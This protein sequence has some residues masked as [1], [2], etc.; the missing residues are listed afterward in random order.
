MLLK[1]E[2]L[3]V[4][5][6]GREILHDINF[7]L[8]KGEVHALL[9][10]NGSGKTSL[11]MTIMGFEKFKVTKGRIIFKGE[12]ITH[13][14][15]YERAKMGI[16]LGFQ[17]PPVVRGVKTRQLI[18]MAAQTQ[19]RKVNVE[20]LAEKLHLEEFLE[21]DI[22]LGFSG[23]EMKRSELVQLLAQ[24]PQLVM[25][26]E[27]ESGVD[28]K[29][30][31]LL[32]KVI[33]ELLERELEPKQKES[34]KEMKSK[35][36]KSALIITHTGHILNFVPAD[37]GHVLIEGHLVCSGNPKEILKTVEKYGYEECAKC[38]R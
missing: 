38:L 19:N 22:N 27:P 25:L 35:R 37:K 24:D 8:P 13:L 5:V 29:N 21:R 28:L 10:P 18:E 2:N 20:A 26:D 32:G 4:E 17:R 36:K 1:I 23:G 12:D 15:V 7:T 3:R 31:A 9:G 16:G 11:V 33:N 34:I 14:P 30:I 6:E